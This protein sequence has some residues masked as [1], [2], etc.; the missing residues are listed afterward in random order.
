MFTLISWNVLADAYVRTAFYPKTPADVLAAGART[1]AIVERLVASDA[2]VICLQEAEPRL[3]DAV[4]G[5]L[6]GYSVA[7]LPKAGGKPDGCATFVRGPRQS[8]T[9]LDVKST[10][11][12]AYADADPPSGHVALVTLLEHDGARIEVANTHLKWDPPEAAP[13][14]RYATRQIA[15]L[16]SALR[17]GPASIV[18]GDFNLTPD[19]PANAAFEAAELADAYADVPAFTVVTS[20]RAKRIDYIRHSRMLSLEPLPVRQVDDGTPLPSHEEPSDHLVIGA[21]VR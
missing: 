8:R 15:Q 11:E 14:E 10:R 2:D 3:V 20:G 9:S 12:I 7:Y 5:R 21:R 16:L 4:S 19:D 1:T 18:C 6:D 17:G 13:S